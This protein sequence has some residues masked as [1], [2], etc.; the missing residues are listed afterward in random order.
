M[1]LPRIV[2]TKII[3]PPRNARTL[4]RPR[5]SQILAGTLEYR[6]TILQAGAGYGKSTALAELAREIQPLIWY[7]VSEEDSDPLVFLLHLFYAT[8]RAL[9]DM[10]DLPIAYLEAWGSSQWLFIG[11][12][13]GSLA[14]LRRKQWIWAAVTAVL[15]T[16]TRSVGV[17]LTIPLAIAWLQEFDWNHIKN[18]LTWKTLGKGLLVLAP[19]AAYW[20]WRSSELGRLF[21][22]VEDEYFGRGLLQFSESWEGWRY[23]FSTLSGDNRQTAIYFGLEL[24]IIALFFIGCLFTLRKHPGPA[25]FG[26]LVLI[27]SVTLGFPQSIS[28]YLLVLPTTFIFL[29]RLGRNEVFDR[30]WTLLSLLLMGMQVALFTFDFWVA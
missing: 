20:L 17:A 10:P 3:P 23:A 22:V 19:L 18:H 27:V 7:Q 28:R 30:A 11:L 5:V 4:P 13:F 26:L 9:P 21:Q 8:R 12:A 14:L 6:L 16:W 24:T 25:L 2:R 29:S 15:A 1:T